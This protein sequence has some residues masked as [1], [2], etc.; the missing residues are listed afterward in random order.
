MKVS[1]RTTSMGDFRL[2]RHLPSPASG[3]EALPMTNWLIFWRFCLHAI[4][5]KPHNYRLWL[6]GYPAKD[7]R[8]VTGRWEGRQLRPRAIILETPNFKW[9]WCAPGFCERSGPAASMS[10]VAPTL[11]GRTFVQALSYPTRL[12]SSKQSQRNHTHAREE[13]SA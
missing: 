11:A 13:A 2:R 10:P 7:V 12:A 9:F 4:V 6:N 3:P 1:Y 5:N 8:T